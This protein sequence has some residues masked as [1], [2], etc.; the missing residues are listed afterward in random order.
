MSNK[1]AREKIRREMEGKVRIGKK[2][3]RLGRRKIEY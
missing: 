1:K 2:R 3:D